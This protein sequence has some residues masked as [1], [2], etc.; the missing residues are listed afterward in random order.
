MP[1]VTNLLLLV[2]QLVSIRYIRIGPKGFPSRAMEDFPLTQ[3]CGDL[4][5]FLNFKVLNLKGLM[6]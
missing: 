2:S 4:A 3:Y 6:V 1:K 5:R